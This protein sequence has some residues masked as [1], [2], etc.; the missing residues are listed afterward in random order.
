MHNIFTKNFIP[1]NVKDGRSLDSGAL[2]LIGWHE[3]KLI[4]PV[5]NR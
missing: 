4:K 2:D 1:Q 5:N 3:P